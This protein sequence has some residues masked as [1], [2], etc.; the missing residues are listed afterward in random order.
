MVGIRDPR[1]MFM[2]QLLKLV[3]CT[4]EYITDEGFMPFVPGENLHYS[5]TG[6][7]PAGRSHSTTPHGQHGFAW[8][9]PCEHCHRRP[10]WGYQL[11]LSIIWQVPASGPLSFLVCVA[12]T[13][14][15]TGNVAFLTGGSTR[16]NEIDVDYLL[17]AEE[18]I[19]IAVYLA[20]HRTLPDTHIWK[21]SPPRPVQDR[22]IPF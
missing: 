13:P 3:D 1:L 5:G 15:A 14:L 2:V 17:S 20:L 6:G 16:E 22:D 7:L 12:R 10:V 21:R 4:L 18:V 11:A 19:Q 8:T 9:V